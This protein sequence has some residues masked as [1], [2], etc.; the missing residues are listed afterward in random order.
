VITASLVSHT[1]AGKTTLAR[2]LLARDIGEVR[3]APHVTELAEPHL[4]VETADGESLMLCDTPGFGDSARLL[5]RLRSRRQPL[6]WFLA[7]VWDRWRDRAFWATQQALLQV[8]DRTD[9][10]VYLVSAAETPAAAGY[11]APEMELLAWVG[12]PVVVLVNQRG[13]PRPAAEEAAEL[14]RW[15][16]ELARWQLVRALLPFDA[17]ARCWVQEHVLLERIAALLPEQKRVSFERLAARW[18]ER[19]EEVFRRSMHV[20]AAQLAAAAAD[21]QVVGSRSLG[22]TARAWFGAADGGAP[23]LER[24]MTE[25]GTRLD[26]QVRSSMDELIRL[27]GLSGSASSEVLARMGTEFAVSK[28]ADP[29]MASALGGALT[30]ALGGLAADLAAG[31]LTFGAG[32]L[33]GGLLGAVGGR[34]AARAYNLARGV[35]ASTVRWSGD[36]LAGRVVAAV[37]RY[38]AVAHFGRGRGEFAQDEYPAHWRGLVESAVASRRARL[39][40][41]WRG[42]VQDTSAPGLEQRLGVIVSE[43]TAEVLASL[44]PV[45]A[46]AQ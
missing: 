46:D 29:G 31:G 10:V 13:A 44:Y 18:R 16:G 20:L 45:T 11:V 4:L 21:A 17:F 41:A 22:E 32:A 19:N 27:H 3:D 38:L 8:R 26:T 2:T 37:M 9:I 1:N 40:A 43:I 36:F 33:I 34:G 7:E 24:A 39:D 5:E 42:A 25:L 23:A 28:A 30:G 14:A 6:G 15:Q 35:D 12:K